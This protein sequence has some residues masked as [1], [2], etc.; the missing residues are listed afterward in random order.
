MYYA[1]FH[2]FTLIELIT[3]LSVAAIILTVGVPGFQTMVQNNRLTTDINRLITDLNLA[4]MEAIKRGQDVTICKRNTAGTD[5]D[6]ANTWDLGWIVFSDPDRDGVV[7]A[8]EEIIRVTAELDTGISLTYG[9]DQVTYDSQGF[10]YGFAG[11]FV[12]SDARGSDYAKT[13]V[14]SN[15]GRIRID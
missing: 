5:C 10:S 9:K 3:T 15:A 11:S 13:R 1:R 4:R 14:I 7:D 12:M 8:G 2:G 6:D